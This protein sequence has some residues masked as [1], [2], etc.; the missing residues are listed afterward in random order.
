M[1]FSACSYPPAASMNFASLKSSLAWR[2]W[3]YA[4]ISSQPA[5]LPSSA[6]AT[7]RTLRTRPLRRTARVRARSLERLMWRATIHTDMGCINGL[8]VR[9]TSTSRGCIGESA[10][11]DTGWHAARRRTPLRLWQPDRQRDPIAFDVGLVTRR[12]RRTDGLLFNTMFHR[13][14]RDTTDVTKLH[15]RSCDRGI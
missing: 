6:A 15:R 13:I 4:S 14:G 3:L 1:T 2:A 7:S 12:C 8:R 9:S 5:A 10:F 11:V